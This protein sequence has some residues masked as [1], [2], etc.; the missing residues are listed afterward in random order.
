[1]INAGIRAVIH[2]QIGSACVDDAA[3]TVIAGLL[4]GR[5]EF[6]LRATQVKPNGVLTG[7]MNYW[8]SKI[9]K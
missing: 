8:N 4:A 5:K 3:K 6:V 7:A 9:T 2:G 1:M